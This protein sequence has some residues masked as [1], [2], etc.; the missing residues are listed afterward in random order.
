MPDAGP[1]SP[2]RPGGLPRQRHPSVHPSK[3]D[4]PGKADREA[5]HGGSRVS[6]VAPAQPCSRNA[7]NSVAPAGERAAPC[8]RKRLRFASVSYRRVTRC[9]G[10][11]HHRG[12]RPERVG[13]RFARADPGPLTRAAFAGADERCLLGETAAVRAPVEAFA[14][15]FTRLGVWCDL[16]E[17]AVPDAWAAAFLVLGLDPTTFASPSSFA[18][19]PFT[20]MLPA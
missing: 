12:F 2:R 13:G 1:R 17:R 20:G 15:G 9:E 16:R 5:A 7:R 19:L 10:P 6:E 18:A 14:F 4:W 11:L 3:R 8:T